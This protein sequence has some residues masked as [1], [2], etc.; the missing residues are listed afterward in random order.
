MTIRRSGRAALA[1]LLIAVGGGC[2]GPTP[3]QPPASPSATPSAADTPLRTSAPSPEPT[4]TA[5]D[6]GTL[7]ATL[8]VE[9][10]G[11]EV[12][13]DL[14]EFASTGSSIV[15]SSG[16]AEDAADGTAP[17]LW[18]Y[19]PGTESEPEMIWH[20][21]AR[22]HSI[23]RVGGDLDTVAWVEMPVDGQRAWN[24]WLRPRDGEAILLDSHP[25]DEAVSSLVPSFSVYEPSIAWTAFDRGPRGPV[26]RMLSATAPDWTPRVVMEVDAG[27]AEL[28]LPSLYGNTVVY[29]EVRY[30]PDR[31]SDERHVYLAD[32]LDAGM[33]PRRLDASGLATMPQ[34]ADDTVLWK[35]ADRG[36]NMFNWGRMFRYDIAS[37]TVSALDTWPQEYVNYPSAGTR[38]VA[39]WG[40]D[41]TALGVYDLV[42]ERAR[43]IERHD[44]RGEINALRPHVRGDLMVWLHA[45]ETGD[46][47]IRELRWAFLPNVREVD[48]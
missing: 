7:A 13:D 33:E 3:S 46:S 6:R 2:G 19:T 9:A 37:G 38:F 34:M 42:R 11:S 17:D 26:S 25:G 32:I 22:D 23:V 1:A 45:D 29:T 21:P 12:T 18:R 10:L 35:E 30:A 15:Y 28:W 20:N 14:L 16:S 43:L 39:W 40:S 4:A 48:R 8:D 44:P 47:R 27:D 41:S 24:L 31:L 36:F 5:S